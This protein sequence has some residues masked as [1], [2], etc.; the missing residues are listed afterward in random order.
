MV[1]EWDFFQEKALKRSCLLKNVDS[2]YINLF[3]K[4]QISEPK[5]VANN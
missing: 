4:S 3:M 5:V 2:M 1:K